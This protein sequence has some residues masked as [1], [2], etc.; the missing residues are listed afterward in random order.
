[1]STRPIL[2][3]LW[4]EHDPFSARVETIGGTAPFV[5][6]NP[7]L[8]ARYVVMVLCRPTSWWQ[9]CA[10]SNGGINSGGPEHPALGR[11]ITGALMEVI[12]TGY[13]AG[14]G[15]SVPRTLSPE[16]GVCASNPG[17]SRELSAI[18]TPFQLTPDTC[19][20]IHEKVRDFV[21]SPLPWRPL[22][23]MFSFHGDR[24]YR[25]RCDGGDLD[26]QFS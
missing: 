13:G 3:E 24:G 21:R 19:D 6:P 14:G 5:P 7:N 22:W 10:R 17:V 4:S 16:V 8:L 12:L 18:S 26:A 20:H 2:S 11:P 23:A 9:T 15:S 25:H 1:M